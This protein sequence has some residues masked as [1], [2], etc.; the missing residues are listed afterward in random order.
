MHMHRRGM[1]A[2]CT[3]V[4]LVISIFV[5][6]GIDGRIAIAFGCLVCPLYVVAVHVWLTCSSC[7]NIWIRPV[8][9]RWATIWFSTSDSCPHCGFDSRRSA[10]DRLAHR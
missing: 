9:W 3:L 4:L 2:N 5:L 10:D 6:M 7:R 1:I 8:D